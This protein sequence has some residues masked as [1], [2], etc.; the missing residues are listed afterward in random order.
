MKESSSQQAIAA[1]AARLI[2]DAGLDYGPAKAKAAHSLGLRRAEWPTNERVEEAVREYLDIFCAE[3]QPAELAA[4]RSVARGWMQR[5][6]PFRPHLGGA[7]WRGTA[8]R[9]S[10]VRIDLY[11]DDPK[12]APIALLNLGIAH[13]VD[14]DGDDEDSTVLTVSSLCRELDER[15]LVHLLVHDLDDLRGA[16][17]PDAQGRSWRGDLAALTRLMTSEPPP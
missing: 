9:N 16:L 6:Q 8:T 11:C 5:L 13:D 7:V 15:V 10:A 1:E 2:V 4:L 17:K 12:S 3:T 14:S